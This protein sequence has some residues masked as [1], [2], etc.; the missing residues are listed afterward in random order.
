M[1]EKSAPSVSVGEAL[2]SEAKGKG[3]RPWKRKNGEK[4]SATAF[5]VLLLSIWAW[6]ERRERRFNNHEFQ[7][8]FALIAVKS[9]NKRGGVRKS[10]IIKV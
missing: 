7:K 10:S 4:E 5:R 1:I 8:M 2:T 6:V 9:D 3:V